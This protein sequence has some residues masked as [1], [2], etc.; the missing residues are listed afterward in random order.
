MVNEPE[1]LLLDGFVERFVT[2]QLAADRSRALDV[3]KAALQAGFDVPAIM[4]GII[5]PSQYELG[6]KWERGEI[7]VAEEHV[8]SAISQSALGWMYSEFPPVRQSGPRVVVACVAGELHDL[9]ARVV[10]DLCEY[11]GFDVTY[12]GANVPNVT[13]LEAIEEVRPD[14]VF[15]SVTMSWNVPQLRTL[16]QEINALDR[17]IPVVVG[18]RGIAWM[19]EVREPDVE[20][21]VLNDP[22]VAIAQFASRDGDSG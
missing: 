13:V 10:A 9:G 21:H 14:V 2:A 22:L 4:L 20:W 18:G 6:E 17:E 16:A 1:T 11:N 19:A 7:S 12:L 8:G 3:V 5:Q 15:L